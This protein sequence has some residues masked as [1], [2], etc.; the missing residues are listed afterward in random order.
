M[1]EGSSRLR[2]LL[3]GTSE[4]EF[5]SVKEHLLKLDCSCEFVR[6]CSDGGM[7]AAQGSFDA[8]LC[9]ADLKDYQ[10]MFAAVLRPSV[11]VF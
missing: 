1:P 5:S 6:S 4:A 3:V 7:S 2:V 10:A 9:K 8:I 11:C